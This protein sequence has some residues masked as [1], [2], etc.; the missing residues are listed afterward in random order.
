[1]KTGISLYPDFMDAGTLRDYVRK[2]SDLGCR[3]VFLSFILEVLNF[4]GAAGPEAAVFD[5]AIAAC[6]AC[7]MQV[8]ADVND[9]VMDA[10]GTPETAVAMLKRRGLDFLR[11]DSELSDETLDTMGRAGMGIEINAAD[12]D[13]SSAS[14]RAKAAAEVER[15][16]AHLPVALV[17]G[18]FNFYPRTGTGLSLARVRDTAA[19]LHGY[20]LEA[21]AFVSSLSAPPV[22]HAR[23]RGVPTAEC[24]R[25]V[26]PEI[27][28][29]VLRLFGVDTVLFG[30]VSATTAELRALAAACGDGVLSLP[31]VYHRDCPEG[32]RR[33]LA[34]TVLSNR[35]DA[36][37]YVLRCTATRGLQVD[38]FRTGPRPR[39]SVTVD[40]CRSAQYEGETQIMLR[41]MPA[42]GETNVAGFIHPDAHIL[43]PLLS[44]R[45]LRF[46]LVPYAG[47]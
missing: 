3:R 36:P 14:G 45:D 4:A 25:D 39:F 29:A 5:E 2:A 40:N 19:F 9:R 1:M 30:D 20:G 11:A 24:L 27:A 21:A 6:H 10:F 26:P 32:V 18:C 13:V 37:E 34:E 22:L 28:A 47:E 17:R 15:L 7:A 46:R 44:G 43:I 23:G 12:L 31:V 33:C 41:D 38:P 35:E 16:L 8:T 42:C